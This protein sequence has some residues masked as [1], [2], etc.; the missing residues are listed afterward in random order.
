MGPGKTFQPALGFQML[1]G[2]LIY[3]GFADR[4]QWLLIR[5]SYRRLLQKGPDE[6]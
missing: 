5:W 3:A 1:S 6:L 2:N 4:D